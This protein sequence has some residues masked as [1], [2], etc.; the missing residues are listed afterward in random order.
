[1]TTE[2]IETISITKEELLDPK[3][4]ERLAQ[5]RNVGPGALQPLEEK[6]GLL[7]FLYS[8]WLYLALAGLVGALI[9]WAIVEPIFSDGIIFTGRV[10]QVAPENVR[11]EQ[12]DLVL[13]VRPMMVSGV[14]VVVVADKTTIRGGDRDQISYTVDDL[15]VD[16]VIK[17]RGE[18][19]RTPEGFDVVV[20][21][22][23][24]I[25]PAGTSAP[26]TIS[27]STLESNETFAAFMLLMLV[28]GLVGLFVGAA[29]GIICRTFKRAVRSGLFGLLT[30]AVCGL[31]AAFLGGLIYEKLSGLSQDFM[32]GSGAFILQ[33]FR[34]G[35]AWM[36]V[37]TGMGLGQGF[38][39]KS[40]RLLLNGFI[41]GLIGGL[42]GGIL[43][44]PIS[45]LLSDPA[46]LSGAEMS[47]AIG[48]SIIGAAVGLMIGI[49]D[50]MTRSAWLRVIAGPLRG[51]EFSFY[52][53]PIRLGSSP[54][55]EIYLFKDPKI[56][57]VHANINKLR[58]TFEIADNNTETGT[59]VNGQRVKRKRLVD[60]DRLQIGDSE[61]VYTTREKKS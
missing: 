60:G 23:I 25:E 50:I 46:S 42:I 32:S 15:R 9:G 21:E 35:L 34:R 59:L 27:L 49:T 22:A 2:T 54:K 47:R 16:S 26:S 28:G 24:V 56:A 5:Q 4:D 12:K 38:A 29:E 6:G 45:I 40:R 17:L 37:G 18:A 30:G 43:F 13:N 41:G 3:I 51:K 52:Q 57:P 20:A 1:M 31:I 58:D 53:S 36:I 10:Q 39:L 14:R 19:V 33:M 61:F 11:V 44:D 48:L 8:T 55:N 7:R